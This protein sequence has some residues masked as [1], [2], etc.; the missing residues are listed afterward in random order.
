MVADE[1]EREKKR[2]ENEARIRASFME[3]ARLRLPV[4]GAFSFSFDPNG[5]VPIAGV[6]TYYVSSRITDSWGAL[7]VESG[8]VLMERRADGAITGVV[9]PKPVIS[10]GNISGAGWK[11]TLAPG[12]S[13]VEGQLKG[14]LILKS[15]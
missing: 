11:L 15:P 14:E 8:G 9:V 3:G 5:A 7:D 2:A 12:W 4:A 10:G 13:V 1:K 6:G